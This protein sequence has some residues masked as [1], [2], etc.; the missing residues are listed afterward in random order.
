MENI[1]LVV[2]FME[3]G[4]RETTPIS[5]ISLCLLCEMHKASVRLLS[6]CTPCMFRSLVRTI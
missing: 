1:L 6:T 5:C 2:F 4:K 3:L